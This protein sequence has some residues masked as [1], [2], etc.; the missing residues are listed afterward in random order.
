MT[1]YY[2]KKPAHVEFIGIAAAGKSLIFQEFISQLRGRGYDVITSK[3]CSSEFLKLNKFQRHIQP[4][5]YIFRDKKILKAFLVFFMYFFRIRPFNWLERRE[6][7]LV[8]KSFI[9]ENFF[10][11][12]Q[13]T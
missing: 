10:I 2:H 7:C 5:W 8:V 11:R 9:L 13:K 3:E 6:Y 12:T 4:L 1:L